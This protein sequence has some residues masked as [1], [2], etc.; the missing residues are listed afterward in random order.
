MPEVALKDEKSSVAC[1]DGVIG[2]VCATSGAP[3]FTPIKWNWDTDTT[4]KSDAG[5]SN[6]FAEGTGVVRKD[7][8]MK[9]HANGDPCVASASNH[10]PEVSSYSSNVFVNGKNIARIG[11]VYNSESD[12]E[13]EITTGATT[14][15]AGG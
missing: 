2:T 13:H 8:A 14:V 3:S 4:Q 5:S 10:A 1:T 15:F 6:V 12:Q 9:A 7:D 11:D